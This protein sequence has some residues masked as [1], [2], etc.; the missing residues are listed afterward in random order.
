MES[1]K[2]KYNSIFNDIFTDMGNKID[3]KS[4]DE[5]MIE[6]YPEPTKYRISTMTM[7]TSFNCNIN[8]EVVI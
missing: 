5:K 1:F 4:T 7:I 3:N 8:L 6:S 2:N